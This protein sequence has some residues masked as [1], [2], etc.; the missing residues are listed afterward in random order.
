M[1]CSGAACRR[2][3]E[4]RRRWSCKEGLGRRSSAPGAGEL[5]PV[6][7][8]ALGGGAEVD[9]T[10]DAA[11][12][13]RRV[14]SLLMGNGE[15]GLNVALQ[16]AREGPTSPVDP[17]RWG[18]SSLVAT[19]LGE[20]GRRAANLAIACAEGMRWPL[21][22]L[23]VIDW[24]TTRA[25]RSAGDHPQ[26]EAM[27]AQVRQRTEARG[28]RLEAERER[29]LRVPGVTCETRLAEGVYE[30]HRGGSDRA[31]GPAGGR[32]HSSARAHAA[33]GTVGRLLS[34]T[35]VGCWRMRR[36]RC[37]WHRP[38]LDLRARSRAHARSQ[39]VRLRPSVV[40]RY[41][42]ARLFAERAARS[43]PSTWCTAW[44]DPASRGAALFTIM[45]RKKP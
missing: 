20:A 40:A 39:R 29:L 36:V 17:R 2:A 5:E 28:Q 16:A 42:T 31:A 41:R 22:L 23:H 43:R 3:V 1:A 26:S 34:S 18:R 6:A 7:E 38:R 4:H 8:R 30:D 10:E 21:M 12:R 32:V 15:S 45:P 24:R 35:A 25:P 11:N 14:S 19:D 13:D 33:R 9:R 27:Q 37:W 44:V